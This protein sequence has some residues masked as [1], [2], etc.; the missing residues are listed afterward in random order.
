MIIADGNIST[1]KAVRSVGTNQAGDPTQRAIEA[2]VAESD[3]YSYTYYCFNNNEDRWGGTPLCVDYGGSQG[4]CP[5]AGEIQKKVL[6][7][8]GTCLCS[9]GW[10]VPDT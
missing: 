6:G 1:V 7:E 9:L 8:W 2:A 3:S 4:Y 5:T 10:S